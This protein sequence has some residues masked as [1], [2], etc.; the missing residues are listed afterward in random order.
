MVT[1]RHTVGAHYGITDW[2]IQ[3]LSAV[4]MVA[5]TVLVLGSGAVPLSVLEANVDRWIDSQ[6][7]TQ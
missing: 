4:V 7:R 5:Y 1:E 3:K 2:L 6:R